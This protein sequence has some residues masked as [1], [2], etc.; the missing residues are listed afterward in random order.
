MGSA[1]R[2]FSSSISS[3]VR[4]AGGVSSDHS[5]FPCAAAV[6]L[7]GVAFVFGVFFLCL[8]PLLLLLALSSV[9][10]SVVVSAAAE[11]RFLKLLLFLL[12]STPFV[13][14]SGCNVNKSP[15]A[16]S[17]ESS[18]P[19]S[20]M[21]AE[22]SRSSTNAGSLSLLPTA[23]LLVVVLD[24]PVPQTTTI[25]LARSSSRTFRELIDEADGDC[26]WKPPFSLR[27][28]PIFHCPVFWLARAAP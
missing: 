27:A 22:A 8:S 10:M 14:P 28:M 25:A 3:P 15:V 6:E 18:S 23:L 7:L 26:R 5:L 24:L 1:L 4:T 2:S 21:T 12:V 17:L 19:P 16:V 9:L 13:I 11:D 20:V